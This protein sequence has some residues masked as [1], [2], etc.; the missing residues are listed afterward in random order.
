MTH[1]KPL[2]LPLI[3]TPSSG[4]SRS[5]GAPSHLTATFLANLLS[6][7]NLQKHISHALLPTYHRRYKII[8]ST[9]HTYLLPL[10]CQLPPTTQTLSGE[11]VAGGYFIWLSLPHGISAKALAKRCKSEE[12]LIVA[13]GGL[14]EVPG[15]NV[16]PVTKFDDCVRLCFTFEEEKRLGEGV[17]RLGLVLGRMIRDE[18]PLKTDHGGEK[19]PTN[20]FW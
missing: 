12:S 19:D 4:S 14:F 1:F 10:G 9:I 6:Q 13:E 7:G 18:E 8:L 15:D 5:G 16:A 3:L 17:E 20:A 11:K 2:A